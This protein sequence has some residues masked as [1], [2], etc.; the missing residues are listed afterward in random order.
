[1][2]FFAAFFLAGWIA[3]MA[4]RTRRPRLFTIVTTIL[5]FLIFLAVP[6]SAF[7]IWMAIVGF[8]TGYLVM[9]AQKEANSE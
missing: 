1:M 3:I 7:D 8:M 9:C 6:G 2:I 4:P 5:V